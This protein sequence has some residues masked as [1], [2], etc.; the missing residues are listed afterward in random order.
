ML[1]NNT[2]YEKKC[3]FRE[4]EKKKNFREGFQDNMHGFRN[5][6]SLQGPLDRSPYIYIYIYIWYRYRIDLSNSLNGSNKSR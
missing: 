5:L 3:Y 4:L 1:V 2:S 6:K